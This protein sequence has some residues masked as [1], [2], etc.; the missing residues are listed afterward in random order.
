MMEDT[1]PDFGNDDIKFETTPVPIDTAFIQTIVVFLNKMN[2]KEWI[3]QFNPAGPL[4]ELEGFISR[5]QDYVG[6]QIL[7]EDALKYEAL[8]NLEGFKSKELEALADRIRA[9]SEGCWDCIPERM[10][11]MFEGKLVVMQSLYVGL[12]SSHSFYIGHDVDGNFYK[13]RIGDDMVEVE[14]FDLQDFYYRLYAQRD[15]FVYHETVVKNKS[16][17]V[18]LICPKIHCSKFSSLEYAYSGYVGHW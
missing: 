4:P 11:V 1:S 7:A 18:G 10:G 2:W 8:K 3:D 9:S 6:K 5:L 13:I 15:K 14:D 17:E 12:N 16:G